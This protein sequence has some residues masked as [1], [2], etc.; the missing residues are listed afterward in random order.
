MQLCPTTMRRMWSHRRSGPRRVALAGAGAIVV[1][2]I[3][4][5]TGG[6]D[7]DSAAAQI[8]GAPLEL[9][10]P[11]AS[12]VAAFVNLAEEAPAPR[13]PAPKTPIDPATLNAATLDLDK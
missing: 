2:A 3:F 9:S 5:G 11:P 7:G 12:E 1:G 10:A 6:P 13:P 4:L 8:P